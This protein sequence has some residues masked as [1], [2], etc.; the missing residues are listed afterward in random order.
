[1]LMIGQVLRTGTIDVIE[2]PRPQNSLGQV[3]VAV[4]ASVISAGTEKAKID[5]GNKSLIAKARARPKE[6]EQVLEKVKTDG[7][8]E[9]YKTVKTRLDSYQPLGY[10]CAG[11]A[12]EVAPDVDGIKIGDLVA[13]AG[14]GY[15]NHAEF[16]AVPQNLVVPLPPAVSTESGAF[17]TIGAIALQGIR[18]AELG[19]GES[20]LVSGL[21]LLGLLAVQML[22]THG[23]RVFGVDVDP[24]ALTPAYQLGAD[25]TSLANDPALNQKSLDFTRGRGF[26]AAIIY[27][28]TKSSEPVILAGNLVRDRAKIV[29]VGES[30]MNIPRSPFYEKELDVRMSRSYGP[31]RYD[32]DYEEAGNDYPIGY[33]RWTE[34]RNMEAFLDMLDQGS[35]KTD[36]LATHQFPL[37]QAR[38]AYDLISGEK[39]KRYIGI[40]LTYQKRVDCG[41][42]KPVIVGTMSKTPSK[43]NILSFAGAGNFATRVL[44]PIFKADNRIQLNMVCTASGLSAKNAAK[45]FGFQGLSSNFSDLLE[46]QNTSAIVI[47]TRHDSHAGLATEALQGGRAVFVE[48]P[49]ALDVSEL[50]EV[51]EAQRGTGGLITVGF[52]RRFAPFV[53]TI[54]QSLGGSKAPRTI[55][56]RINAGK[57]PSDHWT[58]DP[59]IG[60]GRIIGEMCHFLDLACYLADSRPKSVTASALGNRKPASTQDSLVATMTFENGSIA[61][62]VY[63]AEGDTVYSKERV[64]LAIG[65]TLYVIDDFRIL[66]VACNGRITKTKARRQDKGHHAEVRTFI[67]SLE[68]DTES[69][70]LTFRDCVQSTLASFAVVEALA[71]GQ[72]VPITAV[73]VE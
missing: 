55:L 19:L 20:V 33:V 25:G 38:E 47:A 50:Q 5:A 62:I 65:G 1:M 23:C 39:R 72:T 42:S 7:L 36:F 70:V 60:G 57:T 35:V 58:Q 6:V 68:S 26:D 24:N 18:Q 9:T 37:E 32:P 69:D 2:V 3:L 67:D 46:D 51:I 10:S 14:A 22:K 48:K 45:R 63:F 59:K 17:A 53:Q 31:G 52:N 29:I 41:E 34:R 54:H 64:E 30:G 8:M 61:T 12:I 27:A 56:I 40:V 16:V 15:A 4:H 44:M 11:Q 71:S 21:G 73:Q 13:C 49:L 28:A 66:E 43:K